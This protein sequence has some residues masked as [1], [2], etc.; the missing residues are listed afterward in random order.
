MKANLVAG[1]QRGFVKVVVVVVVVLVLLVV[2]YTA[3]SLWWTYS[4]G[5]RAGIIQK[6]GRKGYIF[7]TWEG[8]L[9]ITSVPGVAPT[10]WEFSCRDGEIAKRLEA[11]VGKRVTVHYEQKVGVP[12]DWFGETAYFITG[13]TVQDPQ[14]GF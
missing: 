1:P 11:A 4:D 12:V 10:I 5:D 7:K 3:L 14:P 13:V 9:A 8:E 2:A 6:F